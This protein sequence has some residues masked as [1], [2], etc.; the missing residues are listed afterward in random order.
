[1]T[2]VIIRGAT[3]LEP[4]HYRAHTGAGPEAG[5]TEG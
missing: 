3:E 4:A 5:A 2:A 1:M